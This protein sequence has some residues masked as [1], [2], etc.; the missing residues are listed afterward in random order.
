MKKAILILALFAFI[1]GSACSS[2]GNDKNPGDSD[3]QQQTS[4][5]NVAQLGGG[6]FR[7]YIWDYKASPASWSYKGDMPA[8]VDFYADWCVPCRRVAPIMSELA[9]EY[10]GKIRIYRVNTDAE[11]ELSGVFNISSIPAVLFI[12]ASGKP[13][14]AVGA[15][16]KDS[17]LQVIHDYL[18]IK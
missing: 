1:G 7:Q 17:Y 8:I 18:K 13:E 11:K 14:M 12:P 2:N 9:R 4:A 3:V 5:G 10:Q 15:M 6:Q 16:P